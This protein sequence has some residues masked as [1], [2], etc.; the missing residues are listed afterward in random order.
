MFNNTCAPILCVRGE[1]AFPGETKRPHNW[2]EPGWIVL[3]RSPGDITITL[4][5]LSGTAYSARIDVNG[6]SL[7]VGPFFVFKFCVFN[8]KE[9]NADFTDF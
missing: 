6:F 4:C 9:Q 7:P 8:F 2:T 5:P 1:R 3:F